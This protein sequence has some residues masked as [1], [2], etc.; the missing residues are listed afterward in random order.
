MTDLPRR[1][2][3]SGAGYLASAPESDNPEAKIGRREHSG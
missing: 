1:P 2:A 3:S